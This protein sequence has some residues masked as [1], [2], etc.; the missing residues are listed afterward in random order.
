MESI[1]TLES[2]YL[3]NNP[4]SLALY[5]KGLSSMPG[6]VAKGAY[7][8]F[9]FPLYMERGE[10]CYLYDVDGHRYLDVANHHTAAIAGYRHSKVVEAV[11]SQIGRGFAL[12]HQ[13]G[14]EAELAEELCRRVP[15]VERVRFTNS[16]TE[17]SLHAVRLVRGLTG[18]EKIA[19]FEGAFHGSHDA[20]EVSVA[21]PIDLAGPAD[22]PEPVVTVKGVSCHVAED[23]VVLPLNDPESADR[24]LAEHRDELAGVLFDVR[25][26]VMSV[27]PEFSRFVRDVTHKYGLYLIFDEVVSFS[28]AP[29]GV[30]ELYGFEPDLTLFG[31]IIAGGFPGGALGGRAE[32]MD[33]LDARTGKGF[34]QSGT[35]A[36][37]PMS[38]TAGLA[39][40][41][42]LTDEMY[43]HLNTLGDRIR[44]GLKEAA[45]RVGITT[46]VVGIGPLFGIYF[47]DQE[48][49]NYR[50]GSASD[51]A[52]SQRVYLGLLE[53]GIH[54]SPGLTMHS[55]S[56]PTGRE[57]IDEAIE[58]FERVLRRVA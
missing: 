54:T 3:K 26:G 14:V 36:G 39:T 47:T 49:L 8:T 11:Q 16:G 51:R 57:D 43:V 33:V 21:P 9:P 32:L 29:G 40:L 53:E 1:E 37:N 46:C 2:R 15:S 17:A 42:L 4:G 23:T 18:K 10:G 7:D 13:V 52:L 50:A 41:R 58:A 28:V 35:F 44:R 55:I 38:T 12:G 48:I 30:Q 34:F 22:S 56:I 27:G 24:I 45:D 31:K 6:G 5:E 25:A 20:V 19:K